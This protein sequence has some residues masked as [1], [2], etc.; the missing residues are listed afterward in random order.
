MG[1]NQFQAA[2]EYMRTRGDTEE[3]EV[4]IFDNNKVGISCILL[5]VSVSSSLISWDSVTLASVE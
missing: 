2:Y 4:M 5:S 1:D 3:K